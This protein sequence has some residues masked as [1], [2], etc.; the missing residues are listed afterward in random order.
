MTGGGPVPIQISTATLRSFVNT[1]PEPWE[2]GLAD[3]ADSAGLCCLKRIPQLSS[4]KLNSL[5]SIRLRF[6]GTWG[7]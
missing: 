2:T 1:D 3:V 4:Q 6:Y 7:I 5:N